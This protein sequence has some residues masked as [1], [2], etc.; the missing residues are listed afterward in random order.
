MRIINDHIKTKTFKNVYLIYG[1]EDYLRK[2]Y[3]DKLKSAILPEEDTMNYNYYEGKG[4]DVREIIAMADTMPFFAQNRLLILENTGFFSSTSDELAEYVS[5]VPEDTIMIFVE[6]NADKRNKLFKA[7]SKVG[8]AACMESPNQ[9]MLI[10]WIGG[11]LK[12]E[13]RYISREDILLF[14]SI[15]DMDMENI[16]Q[17]LEK[18]ICYTMGKTAITAAD[19]KEVCSVH[20]ENKIFDMITAVAGKNKKDAMALYNDLL[21]LKEPPMR[22]LYL[23]ARQFNTLLLI[24]ELVGQGFPNNTIA[25][26]LGMKEFVIRRNVG[27]ARKFSVEELKA[28]VEFCTQMEED[29]K[30][31]KMQDQIAVELVI[32]RYT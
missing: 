15:I 21:T 17:E 30:S 18:L 22:I 9:E 13:G 12:Q 3:R 24:R 28:A 5:N 10:K 29:V 14:L 19:I 4:L 26:R 27:L 7:V 23:M 16:R 20:T 11:I 32:Y 25:E 6:E 2:Q 1:P 31:G 8:Y